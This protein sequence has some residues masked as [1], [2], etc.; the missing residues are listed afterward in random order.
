MG[1]GV[2]LDKKD[3][4][5]KH[6]KE[7]E[8]FLRQFAEDLHL[9]LNISGMMKKKNPI[10]HLFGE[11]KLR[12]RIDASSE[13]AA[14]YSLSENIFNDSVNREIV[15][16]RTI[17]DLH[18]FYVDYRTRLMRLGIILALGFLMIVAIFLFLKRLFSDRLMQMA[19]ALKHDRDIETGSFFVE[20]FKMVANAINVYREKLKRKNR[21]LEILSH[22]DPLTG[23][24]NRRY[25]GVMLERCIDK[26]REEGMDFAL[27]VFDID[28]FKRIN[29]RYG[30]DVGDEVLKKIGIVVETELEEGDMLFRIGGE[31]FAILQVSVD[32]KHAFELAWRVRERV[33][34]Q[35]FHARFSVSVSVGVSLFESGES[36]VTLY[37]RVDE[38]LYLSK[39][40]GKDTVTSDGTSID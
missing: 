12:Y 33:R 27:I 35:K 22:T 2:Y 23:V 16:L 28:D 7:K 3:F 20:E 31:E 10:E 8:D 37:R 11:K 39:K 14:V 18:D 24:Y 13:R 40:R 38:Y 19:E 36:A 25:F 9:D 29:D 30:H 26:Y 15:I 1:S 34:T 17:Y 21:E 6:E 4:F 32:R 5:K